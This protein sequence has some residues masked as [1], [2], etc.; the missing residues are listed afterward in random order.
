[1]YMIYPLEQWLDDYEQTLDAW[2]EGG[3]GGGS[4]SDR[5]CSTRKS[6]ASISPIP[7][8]RE[9]LATFAPEPAIYR[10]YGVEPPA[11]APARSEKRTA[12]ARADQKRRG[13]RAGKFCSSDQDSAAAR[14]R[15]SRNPFGALSL[16][17][18]IEDTLRAFP[19]AQGVVIDGAGEHP[20]RAR[21]SPRRRAVR[22][23]RSRAAD[24]PAISARMSADWK[25]GSPI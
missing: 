10:K 12:A 23:A 5:W 9:R 11:E 24:A 21:L 2:A 7:G 8:R 18:G 6:P 25:K 4:S 15:S 13:A 22:A 1:M 3:R 17:A 20:L 14:N 19:E 16:A